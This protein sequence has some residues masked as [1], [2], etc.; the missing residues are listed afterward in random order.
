V[1]SLNARATCTLRSGFYVPIMPP[2]FTFA[3]FQIPPAGAYAAR[4]LSAAETPVQHRHLPAEFENLK[5]P[6]P[7]LHRLAA[8]DHLFDEPHTAHTILNGREIEVLG[9][10]LY[11]RFVG[12][13][14]IGEIAVNIRKRL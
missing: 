13:N 9:I 11:A 4:A 14:A 8:L 10:G 7:L 12:T 2:E 3:N 1:P 5:K 6:H